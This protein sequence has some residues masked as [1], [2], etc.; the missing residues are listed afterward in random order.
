MDQN[1]LSNSE[2]IKFMVE[3]GAIP[4]Y[5]CKFRGIN[6]NDKDKNIFKLIQNSSLWFSK[7]ENFNDPFDY[8]IKSVTDC[9]VDE[10]RKFCTENLGATRFDLEKTVEKLHSNP[11]KLESIVNNAISE[12]L[13]NDGI[14]C[15]SGSY[16]SILQ[17]SHYAESHQGICLVYDVL[18]D[19]DLFWIPLP[20]EYNSEYPSFNYI[21]NKKE[22]VTKVVQSKYEIW[23]Y[24]NEVRVIKPN[25]FGLYPVK[26]SALVKVIFGCSCTGFNKNKIIQVLEENGYESNIEL[27][28]ANVSK[29][30]YELEFTKIPR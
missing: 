2:S 3:T 10:L 17:W 25:K 22:L 9:T 13:N 16:E 11:N 1:N 5:L 26:K 18:E 7:H 12:T 6:V 28:Q 30:K 21:K 19:P 4:R 23:G 27:I 14:C 15:F 20:V 8:K 29:S 24:E